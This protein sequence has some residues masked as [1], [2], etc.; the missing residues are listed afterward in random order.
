[1]FM[2]DEAAAL[3]HLQ[4][5]EDGMGYL[6]A[7]AR[8]VIIFQDLGQAQATYRKWRSLIANAACLVTFGV[9]DMD[10]AELVSKMIGERTVEVRSA[11]VNTGASTVLAH[12]ENSGVGEAG[13]RVMLPSEVMRMPNT[14]ALVFMRGLAHPIRCRRVEYFKERVFE[15]LWD[16]WREGIAPVA[17]MLEHKPL[18]LEFRLP[19]V[20][21]ALL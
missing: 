15:G 6:R 17:L 9:N 13:R 5:L 10:T 20:R 7:Y 2:L 19:P 11:G 3:G 21:T 8:A 14:A 16:R 4:E 18:R 12:H 1:M